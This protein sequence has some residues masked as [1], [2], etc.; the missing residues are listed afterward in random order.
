[1]VW[2]HEEEFHLFKKLNKGGGGGTCAAV[3]ST[4]SIEEPVENCSPK[5]GPAVL[6][7][8]DT[9]PAVRRRVVAV[10]RS[11]TQGAVEAPD[12]I[13]TPTHVHHT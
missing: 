13:H 10:D 2:K 4:D 6:H 8:A 7:T 1:M 3:K 5:C 12:C 9:R 11:H